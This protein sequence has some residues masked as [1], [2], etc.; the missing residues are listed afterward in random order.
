MNKKNIGIVTSSRAD[1]GLLRNVL[2][3]LK[4]KSE[5][6]T[7]VVVTGTH[8]SIEFGNTYHEIEN[9]GIC[10][11]K[12]IEIL[13]NSDNKSSI[14]KSMGLAMFE[15]STYFAEN[16]FDL[17]I[18][19]GDRFETMAICIAAINQNI[20]I[21][22][23]YGGEITEGSLD[24]IY[25][26]AIT[27]MSYLHF[28]STLEHRN[29]VIQLGEDPRRVFSVGAM[30]VEN[31]MLTPTLTLSQLEQTLHFDL[32]KPYAL[33]T[34]H[35]SSDEYK[36]IANISNLLSALESIENLHFIFTKSNA[37]SGGRMINNRLYEYTR[38]NSKKAILVDSMGTTNYLSALKYCQM[39]IGNSSS[40]LVEAPCYGRPTINIG[41]RQKGRTRGETI[42][43]CDNEI[44]SIINAIELAR[45][46][47]FI[48]KAKSSE[49]PYGNGNSSDLIVNIVLEK[50]LNEEL[51]VKK[52]FYD[53]NK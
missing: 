22:H 16:T 30:G 32:C 8:L 49:N 13:F 36:E 45:T 4:E 2:F 47:S 23:L 51:K 11:D 50:L 34:Y 48:S 5:V 42:I 10:I 44:D 38:K 1:Y 37:D 29:R 39:V 7:K 19:L 31:A 14:S 41:E 28:T 26:H 20:P 18:V 40:G 43:D 3:K 24:E 27:K 6:V 35:S 25:R 21:A 33:V 46:D 12:K 52:E 53:L 17:L 9:D 15:F